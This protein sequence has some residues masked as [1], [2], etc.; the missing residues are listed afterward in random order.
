MSRQGHNRR[1]SAC[2]WPGRLQLTTTA[3]LVLLVLRHGLDHSLAASVGIV[4]RQHAT[5]HT[6][7]PFMMRG[8]HSHASQTSGRDSR[9]AHMDAWTHMQ[10][11]A[12]TQV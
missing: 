6:A 5:L 1:E 7:R 11:Q 4:V 8:R 10:Q 3:L 12:T 9:S 2:R